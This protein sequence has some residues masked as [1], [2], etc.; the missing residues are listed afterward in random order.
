MQA[1]EVPDF[2]FDSDFREQ[3]KNSDIT[4]VDISSNSFTDYVV[5]VPFIATRKSYFAP[6][7]IEVIAYDLQRGLRVKMFFSDAEF[8]DF[9]SSAKPPQKFEVERYRVT[10]A[11][12]PP[13]SGALKNIVDGFETL[14]IAEQKMLLDYAAAKMEEVGSSQQQLAGKTRVLIEYEN[15]DSAG[16]LFQGKGI[17]GAFNL[18]SADARTVYIFVNKALNSE[19]RAFA[20]KHE[21]LEVEWKE[22]LKGRTSQELSG[23]TIE[24]AAH[25]LAWGEQI[26]AFEQAAI[27]TPQ[28]RF[29]KF[30]IDAIN[31]VK[32]LERLLAEGQRI[33]HQQLREAAF[34]GRITGIE[35]RPEISL[36][37]IAAFETSVQD[38]IKQKINTLHG[39]EEPRK[40]PKDFSLPEVKEDARLRE[41]LASVYS[42]SRS[43]VIMDNPDAVDQALSL[44]AKKRN[45]R[46]LRLTLNDQK[47]LDRVMSRLKVSDG[48]HE[49]L[50][51]ILPEIIQNGGILFIDYRG[52]KPQLI[53]QFNSL[54]DKEPYFGNLKASPDLIIAGAISEEQ[55]LNSDSTFRSRFKATI[56]LTDGDSPGY[57]DLAAYI[58]E[59]PAGTEGI[60]ID[61]FGS[62]NFEDELLGRYYL[63]EAGNIQVKDGSFIQAI[64]QAR[65]LIIKGDNWGNPSFLFFIRQVLLHRKVEFNGE[66]LDLPEGFTI[67]RAASNYR[68]GVTL[69]R[70]ISPIEQSLQEEPLWLI[71][72][73]TQ[74]MLFSRTHV[75]AEG[76]LAQLPGILERQKVRLRITDKLADWVWHM[77][78]HAKAEIEIEVTADTYVPA[79]YLPHK[80]E[81]AKRFFPAR[82]IIPWEEAKDRKVVLVEGEDLSF[83]RQRIYDDLQQ[84]LVFYPATTETTPSQLI[85]GIHIQTQ[86]NHER[87]FNSQA[88]GVITALRQGKTVIL[89]GLEENPA[90]L[91]EFS[92]ALCKTP[93]L[94]ENGQ[95]LDLDTLPGK[96][97]ITCRSQQAYAVYAQNYVQMPPEDRM[98]A[99]LLKKLFTQKF[100]DQDFEKIMRLRKIFRNIPAP[101]IVG[102]YSAPVNLSFDRM[103]MLYQHHNGWLQAFE[104]VVVAAYAGS[105]EVAAFIRTMVRLVFGIEEEGHK[106][107]TVYGRK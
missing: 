7:A 6:G 105:P 75:T 41:R 35:S 36:D 63:D 104:D 28:A 102:L 17:A 1:K 43:L 20:V 32:I 65:P 96:L 3:L 56:S 69:K 84:E 13:T 14:D 70:I 54:F 91:A 29:V 55:Y 72:P 97:I 86:E 26:N 107:R 99:L 74:D 80:S 59:A 71:N 8:N 88:K 68:A 52:S 78:M 89:E 57:Q 23:F 16:V 24:Q 40:S 103:V 48:K 33:Q 62:P 51:G 100:N 93:Y 83:I 73:Q 31:D 98:M 37:K 49:I 106:P 2:V 53:E 25:I 45:V 22:R 18:L 39:R 87:V 79:I 27:N 46:Y 82:Q 94:M 50:P 10:P 64:R 67:F 4:Q 15:Q 81:E 60:E 42:T 30:Q 61:L 66:T 19:D 5:N 77:I 12:S 90:L 101:S 95:R 58:K 85:A 92:S 9:I 76:K 47:D 34:R 38:Y 44:E 21:E 11:A